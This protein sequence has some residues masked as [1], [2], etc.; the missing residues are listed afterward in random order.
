[1]LN[2]VLSF[3]ELVRAWPGA[4]DAFI[5]AVRGDK[6]RAISALR[7]AIDIGWRDYWWRL[8]FPVYESMREEPEWLA[9][10]H[11]IEADI[12][13]QRQWFEEQKNNPLF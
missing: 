8:R 11:D 7:D 13:D 10:I 1:M 12:A 2:G 4:W 6:Q 3:R 5:H 9:L